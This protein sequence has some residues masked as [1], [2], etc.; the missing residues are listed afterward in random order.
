MV[1][2]SQPK[3]RASSSGKLGTLKRKAA[4][5]QLVNDSTARYITGKAGDNV[6]SLQE[7]KD[8]LKTAKGNPHDMHLEKGHANAQIRTDMLYLVN[9]GIK[10]GEGKIHKVKAKELGNRVIFINA[11]LARELIAKAPKTE[12]PAMQER[13]KKVLELPD[14]ASYGSQ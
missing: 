9:K 7:V 6:I 11:Q 4:E 5:M 12:K 3:A 10:D 8:T 2:L 14:R 1:S 13:L